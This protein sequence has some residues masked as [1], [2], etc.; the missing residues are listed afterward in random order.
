[1]IY[2]TSDTHFGHERIIEYCRRP[3]RD[4]EHMHEEL[5]RRWNARVKPED[6]VYHLGDFA[7]GDPGLWAGYRTRLN[8]RIKLILGNHDRSHVVMRAAGFEETLKWA[9]MELDGHWVTCVHAPK[10]P[11]PDGV[12]IQLCGHVHEAWVRRGN[13]INVGVDVRGFE[14]K[15]FAELMQS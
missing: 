4:L 9:K 11:W 14:P 3:F 1:M 12:G 6:T 5:V 8:G 15:T 13:V 10:H 7:M 2:F